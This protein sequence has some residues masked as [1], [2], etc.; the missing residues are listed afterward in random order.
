M[1]GKWCVAPPFS[2]AAAAA[3]AAVDG[4]VIKGDVTFRRRDVD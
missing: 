1:E 2:A 4:L 3:A